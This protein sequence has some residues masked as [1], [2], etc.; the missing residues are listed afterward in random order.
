MK[1]FLSLSVLGGVALLFASCGEQA[2]PPP[3]PVD[4]AALTATI[5]AMEDAFA[6]GYT[7]KDADAVVAYYADDVVSYSKEKEPL[8]GKDAVRQ[9]LMDSFAKDTV[10]VKPSYKVVEIFL[11]GDHLTEIGSSTSVDAAGNETNHGTYFSVFKKAGDHWQ[12][13]RDI[14]VSH[15]PAEVPVAAM[16]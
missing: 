2:P 11:E 7:A 3:P 9:D 15:K 4:M 6:T 12:C 13:I 16:P 14:S 1:T 8:R 10:G 5:Q